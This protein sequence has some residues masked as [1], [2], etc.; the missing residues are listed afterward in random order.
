[1]GECE[2]LQDGSL[3][4]RTADGLAGTDEPS[5]TER[6]RGR[7]PTPRLGTKK[8]LTAAPHGGGFVVLVF[9]VFGR[10]PRGKAAKNGWTGTISS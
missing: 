5:S 9:S 4:W 2:C 6:R 7:V 1:V 3:G 10:F 8:R